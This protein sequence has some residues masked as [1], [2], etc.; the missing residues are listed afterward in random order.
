MYAYYFTLLFLSFL[1]KIKAQSDLRI[2][3]WRAF[4]PYNTGK[5]VTQSPEHVFWSTGLS[6]LKMAKSDFQLKIGKNKG[7]S[8]VGINLIRYNKANKMLFVFYTDQTID[9]VKDDGSIE[10]LTDIKNNKSIIGDKSVNDLFFRGDT[11]FFSGEFWCFAARYA[12]WRIY[13]NHFY[14]FKSEQRGCF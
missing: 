12:A 14:P 6:V 4:M 8:A 13:F 5:Y 9:L 1:L 11:A 2:G 3:D 10:T 7:L